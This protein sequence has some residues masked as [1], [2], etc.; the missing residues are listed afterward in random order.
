[1]LSVTGSPLQVFMLKMWVSQRNAPSHPLT[2]RSG[3]LTLRTS[4]SSKSLRKAA[5]RLTQRWPRIGFFLFLFFFGCFCCFYQLK[6]NRENLHTTSSSSPAL[7]KGC[8]CARVRHISG[9][10]HLLSRRTGSCDGTP[11]CHILARGTVFKI[12]FAR[13][14]G[15]WIDKSAWV[16]QLRGQ[17]GL[18]HT[19]LMRI[20]IYL[21]TYLVFFLQPYSCQPSPWIINQFTADKKFILLFKIGFFFSALP[22]VGAVC[23]SLREREDGAKDTKVWGKRERRERKKRKRGLTFTSGAEGKKIEELI[24]ERS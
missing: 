13:E 9:H 3:W 22:I 6:L 11:R 14:A 2:R 21:F 4:H 8:A 19:D 23:K 20:Y 15:L 7:V 12:D 5:A 24:G 16:W 18:I 17:T 10:V 1:M